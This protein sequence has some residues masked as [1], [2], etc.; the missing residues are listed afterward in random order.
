MKEH[1]NNTGN[2]VIRT[3]LQTIGVSKREKNNI[4][5]KTVVFKVTETHF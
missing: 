2:R 3:K 5:R 1:L 4:G